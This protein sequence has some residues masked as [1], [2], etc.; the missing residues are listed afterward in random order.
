MCEKLGSITES[1]GGEEYPENNKT[2]EGRTGHI[3]CRN[4]LLK[5]V[6]G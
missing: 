3:L 4:C 1:E 2:K 5:H 6:T